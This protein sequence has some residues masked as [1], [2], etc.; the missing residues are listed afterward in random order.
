MQLLLYFLAAAA[1]LAAGAGL[2]TGASRCTP[3]TRQ[4][5]QQAARRGSENGCS[6]HEG[7]RCE[8]HDTPTWMDG[9]MPHMGACS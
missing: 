6:T 1:G 5:Q 2:A 8:A 3:C 4:Q 7:G 9:C